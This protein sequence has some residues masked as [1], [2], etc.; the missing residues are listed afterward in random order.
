MECLGIAISCVINH[1][2]GIAPLL[3]ALPGQLPETYCLPGSR[4][5]KTS[6]NLVVEKLCGVI[7]VF[8]DGVWLNQ[9]QY[10]DPQIRCF[11]AFLPFFKGFWDVWAWILYFGAKVGRQDP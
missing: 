11:M 7:G 8:R 5:A 6:V 1:T 4:T 3:P 9:E 2:N 10:E